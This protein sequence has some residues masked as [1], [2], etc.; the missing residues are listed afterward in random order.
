MMMMPPG[1]TC[2]DL[3]TQLEGCGRAAAVDAFLDAAGAGAM[4]V[5]A[6]GAGSATHDYSN[7]GSITITDR[8]VN[9]AGR[10]LSGYPHVEFAR[11]FNA[12]TTVELKAAFTATAR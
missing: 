4:A 5:V 12:G 2:T 9:L 1:E 6:D 11:S 7:G 8:D 3:A 10:A